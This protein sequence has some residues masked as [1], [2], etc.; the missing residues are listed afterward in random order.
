M[1]L[2]P[3]LV[4]CVLTKSWPETPDRPDQVTLRARAALEGRAVKDVAVWEERGLVFSLDQDVA[5]HV[6]LAGRYLNIAVTVGSELAVAWQGGRPATDLDSPSLPDG[7]CL[8]G[9]VS[10][11]DWMERVDTR[12]RQERERI[13]LERRRTSLDRAARGLVR[14]ER[15]ALEAAERDLGR[16]ASSEQDRRYGELLKTQLHRVSRG[17][18]EVEVQDYM[19][20]EGG[21]VVIPLDPSMDAV[22]NMERYFKRYRRFRDASDGIGERHHAARVR[23]EVLEGLRAV[24]A[25]CEQGG[26]MDQVEADL[27][28]HGWR[29]PQPQETSSRARKVERLPYQ[30]FI[31]RGGLEIL[32]GRT[33]ADNDTLT[34]RVARGR[35]IWLHARDVSGS[36]VVLR[37]GGGK[38]DVPREALLDAA[39]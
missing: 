16:V 28:T 11:D 36:H 18:P 33:A 27:R 5:L 34:F 29:P 10:G 37:V 2:D 13:A 22:A 19:D 8:L 15:R 20:P 23:V 21:M 31:A 1:D 39:A 38:Q 4:C 12:M 26:E 17:A 6:Q 32:V 24:L 7:A 3:D 30:R 35:D 25:E 9:E 14:R